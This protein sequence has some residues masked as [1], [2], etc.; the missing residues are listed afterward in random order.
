MF[1][2]GPLEAN[3]PVS[4]SIPHG[5]YASFE[6]EGDIRRFVGETLYFDISFLWFKNAASAQVGFYEK[7][8]T[9]FSYL[10]AQTK[11]IVGF[12]T[13][14]RK[15][16]YKSTLDIIDGGRRVRANRFERKVI[17]G[18]KVEKSDHHFD[19]KTRIH[20][21]FEYVNDDLVETGQEEIPLG[22]T[23]DDVLTAFYNF[24]NGV[25][26]RVERG[27]KYDITTI[28]DKGF[29]KISVEIN[30]AAEEEKIRKQEGRNNRN[31]FLVDIIVPKKLFNTR[32][33]KIRLWSSKHLIPLESTIKDYIF[34]G[35]LHAEF[36]KRDYERATL[37]GVS[38]TSG[39]PSRP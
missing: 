39:I 10:S 12:F 29:Q 38:T 24:R 25:Y 22:T 18:G 33:G 11:G 37:T 14:Y 13:A 32:S 9:Y 15:H 6:P 27:K 23:F 34:L 1:I 8:G 4:K 30:D 35:D 2:H 36:R 20:K 7:N 5:E 3:P 19:Y 31:E 17:E 16:I 21:W 26:G 28:P